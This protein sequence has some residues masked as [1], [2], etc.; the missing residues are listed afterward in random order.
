MKQAIYKQRGGA[1]EVLQIVDAASPTP[2]PGEVLVRVMASG[3][4]PSDVKTRA[5]ASGPLTVPQT[6][7]HNDGGGII[8][9]V[10]PGVPQRRIGERVWLFNVNRTPDGLGQGARGTAALETV[11][12]SALAVPLVHGVSFE[13]AACLGVPAM[14]AH[15]AV[16][17]DGPVTGQTVLVTGGAGAVGAMAIQI[18]KWSGA[19]VIATVSSEDKARAAREDGADAVIN[20]KSETVAARALELNGGQRVDRIVDVD[21]A[22]HAETATKILKISGVIAAYASM[23]NRNPVIPFGTLM[24][25]DTTVRMIIVYGMPLEAKIA[26][27][28]DISTMLAEGRMRPR[29]AATFALDR[30]VEAHEMQEKGTH[31]GNVVLTMP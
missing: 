11:V 18:A 30:I 29:I 9:A 13:A 20:Y 24:F 2:G 17:A 28:R 19:R 10:G 12:E 1:R 4:N 26:A 25:M 5:G 6:V 21:F 7:P 22:A 15:R 16:L 31:I 3:V 8:T 27:I 14:T 23:S